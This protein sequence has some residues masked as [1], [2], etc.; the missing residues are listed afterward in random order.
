VEESIDVRNDRLWPSAGGH[1]GRVE[2][3]FATAVDADA[4]E[5]AALRTAVAQRLTEDFGRGHWSGVVT[6]KSVLHAL[7][8]S[9]VLVARHGPDIVGTLRLA[10]KKPWAIDVAYFTRVER[11]LYLT[12]MAVHSRLQRQGIGRRLLDEA[13]SVARGW[14]GD[15]IRLD[16][17]DAAAGA[18]PFYAKCGLSEVGRVTYRGTPLIYFEWVL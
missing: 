15:A 13:A 7:K 2:L 5:I 3:R 1:A 18:G 14:P 9:R 6:E 17:Y 4:A 10:T 12:D 8:T 11:P 16:S